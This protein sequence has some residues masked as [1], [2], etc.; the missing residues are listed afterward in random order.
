MAFDAFISYSSKDKTAANAACAVLEGAGVRCWIAPRDIRPGLEYGA[1]I[2]EAMDRC[3][4]M[5]LIFSSSANDSVQIHREIERAVTKAVPIVPVRI[6]EVA[7]TKSMEYFLGGIHWLDALTPPIEKHLLH[8]AETVKAI[9]QVDA[10][11]RGGAPAN[12]GLHKS[13]A[14][15][16]PPSATARTPAGAGDF[17]SKN[18]ARMNWLLPALGGGICI[19]LI[20]AGVWLYQTR[21]H[22][23][24]DVPI[25]ASP[26]PA[27]KTA[28]ALV[29]E[30]V[31][32]I[33]D[34]ERASIR[35]I[36][37]SA[38]DH[39]AFAISTRLGFITGQKDEATAKTA[40]LEAC[41]RVSG[42]VANTCQLYAVGNAVVYTGGRPPMPPEPWVLRDPAIE[43][44]FVAKDV[45]LV[46]DLDRTWLEKNV[47]PGGKPK[48]VAIGPG[49]ASSFWAQ[50]S[51]DEA[52]RRSLERCG[53]LTGVA[54]MIVA[55]D[56]VFVVPIPTTMEATG[57]FRASD[58]LMIA[59]D[60]REAVGRRLANATNGWNA[61]AVGASGRAGL[62]L[63][64]A[65]EQAAIDGALADCGRQDRAC[66]V[67]AIGPFTVQPLDPAKVTKVV[68]QQPQ[69]PTAPVDTLVPET[70]P[71]I[72]FSFR[73]AI[74]TDYLSAPDHKALAIGGPSLA[75]R[76]AFMTGQ[77]DEETAKT[78]A[79]AACQ[80]VNQ[81]NEKCQLYA[82]GNK[83]VYAGGFPPL[84]PEPWVVRDPAIERPFEVKDVPL[85]DANG[86]T[87]LEKTHPPGRKPKALA[88]SQRGRVA[89]A[90]GQSS[91]EEAVRRS[92]EFCGNGA[93]V[94]CMIVAIDDTFVVPIPTTMKVAG[95]FRASNTAIAPE[96][97]EDVARRLGS[98]AGGWS[99]VAV[100][101]GGR[102]GLMLKAANEQEAD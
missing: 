17:S 87:W 40:A 69:H 72:P 83:V 23:P 11:A 95:F 32:F 16:P 42:V 47:V 41:K 19:A 85:V 45:P 67:I 4:V 82:V 52:V 88:L 37:L 57:V 1:A 27:P 2:I 90:S 74:R 78:A 24:A 61:V 93:G 13:S 62:M 12:D 51:T 94:A 43:K 31:P 34:S 75:M 91:S 18:P 66:H 48:A 59:P 29:P 68:G 100:G 15:S 44:P 10:S 77:K 79:L 97:R 98:S 65:N 3:R 8:L 102:P 38:P 6:E 50:L 101:A 76:S 36:Y 7:P 86:R 35:N 55:V 80:R 73:A 39:K 56:D 60:A 81:P 28:E 71:F 54:C 46:R 21:V 20:A 99:A 9:L 70:V 30:T 26:P 92:L 63:K 22:A 33:A 53:F 5:V 64:A 89:F 84:P 49:R 58:A 96:A 25:A 14:P